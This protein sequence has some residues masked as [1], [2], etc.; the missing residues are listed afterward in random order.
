LQ[1]FFASYLLVELE[2][3]NCFIYFIHCLPFIEFITILETFSLL[4]KK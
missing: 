4:R 2:I 1:A 3:A